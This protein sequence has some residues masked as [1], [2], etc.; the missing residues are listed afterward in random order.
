[1]RRFHALLLA[2]GLAAAPAS[3][4]AGPSSDP[5]H[6]PFT[7]EKVEMATNKGR[8]GVMVMSLTP[9]LRRHFGAADDRGVLVAQVLPGSPAAAAG[10]A[11]GDVI[12][13]VQGQT[14]DSA[15][16]MLGVLAGV[17]KG[18]TATIRVVR[19]RKPKTIEAKLTDEP[20]AAVSDPTFPMRWLQDLLKPFSAPKQTASASS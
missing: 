7:Y 9:E 15:A 6:A 12:V 2:A 17:T 16:D 11:V 3:A 19:D 4:V 10:V 20:S 14:V 8:L 18:Q 13:E 1:M 5:W